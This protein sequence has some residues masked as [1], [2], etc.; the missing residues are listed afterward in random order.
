[1]IAVSGQSP[2]SSYFVVFGKAEDDRATEKASD[3][4]GFL[5]DQ[6]AD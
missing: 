5:R 4:V 3:I 1:M 6:F 2:S